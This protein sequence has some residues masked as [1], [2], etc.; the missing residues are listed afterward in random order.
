VFKRNFLHCPAIAS[1]Q[2]TQGGNA[3]P[4][5][6]RDAGAAPK[7]VAADGAGEEVARME[8]PREKLIAIEGPLS[9]LL[10]RVWLLLNSRQYA[11]LRRKAF[12]R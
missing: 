8:N 7:Q 9:A 4:M 6:E 11:R 10:Q 5:N 2:G 1:C 12:Q 3:K